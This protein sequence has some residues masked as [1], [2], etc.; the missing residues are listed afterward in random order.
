MTDRVRPHY[1]DRN[2]VRPLL[3][4][5]RSVARE[6][7]RTWPQ[8]PELRIGR[9]RLAS[10]HFLRSP[11]PRTTTFR[12]LKYSISVKES[13]ASSTHGAETFPRTT[14]E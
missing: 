3:L 13:A 4:D 6:Q 14:A 5:F 11:L 2:C 7:T 1:S 10:F 12:I 8:C 9:T